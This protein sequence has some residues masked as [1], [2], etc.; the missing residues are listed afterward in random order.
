MWSVKL[1]SCCYEVSGIFS[2][3]G[4]VS[5]WVNDSHGPYHRK[6]RI[7]DLVIRPDGVAFQSTFKGWKVV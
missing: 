1:D 2:A 7:G 4:E 5:L 6:F 3:P